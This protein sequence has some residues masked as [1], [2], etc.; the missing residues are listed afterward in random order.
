MTTIPRHTRHEIDRSIT[1]QQALKIARDI[2]LAANVRGMPDRLRGFLAEEENP[3]MGGYLSTSYE[4]AWGVNADLSVK[5]DSRVNDFAETE[6]GFW[7]ESHVS[8]TIGWSSTGRGISQ[9][10]AA[11]TLYQELIAL[12]AEI[13]AR[14]ANEK[15]LD[16]TPKKK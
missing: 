8:V 5:L 14:L 15:I 7:T 3:G 1:S 10:L 2:I 16:F 13:E 4:R 11:V 6:D 12:G 9:A